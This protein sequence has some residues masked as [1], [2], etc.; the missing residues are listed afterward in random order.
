MPNYSSMKYSQIILSALQRHLSAICYPIQSAAAV[1]EYRLLDV[2]WALRGFR[3]PTAEDASFVAKQVTFIFKSFERQKQARALVK[4]IRKYYPGTRMVIADD[5]SSPL[6]IPSIA[7]DLTIIQM[8]FNSGLSKGLNLALAEVN[9][10][11]NENG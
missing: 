4:S 1:I 5:S 11:F 9:T 6:Q 8:P 10:P 7:G 2:L 3:K